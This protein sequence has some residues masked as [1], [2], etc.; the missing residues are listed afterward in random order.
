MNNASVDILMCVPVGALVLSI[1]LRVRLLGYRVCTL[2]SLLDT[3]KM[4]FKDVV[5]TCILIIN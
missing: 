2:S 1:N 4:I 3:D 5:T